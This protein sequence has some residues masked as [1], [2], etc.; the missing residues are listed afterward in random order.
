MNYY[1]ILDV[2][3]K[4]SQETIKQSYRS[5]ALK[6]HPDRHDATHKDLASEKF[7]EISEAYCVLSVCAQR[8]AYDLSLLD[9]Q[10]NAQAYIPE[11]KYP[12][13]QVPLRFF[14]N[15]TAS[16]KAFFNQKRQKSDRLPAEWFHRN[17]QYT[18]VMDEP[19]EDSISLI[20]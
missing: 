18:V 8:K 16:E 9:D 17:E 3:Q 1:E 15:Y 10:I 6:W 11:P 2:D 14:E 13:F 19:D 7:K 20:S 5:L 4:A 12:P